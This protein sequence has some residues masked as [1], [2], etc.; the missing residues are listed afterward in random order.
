MKLIN[1][2]TIWYLGISIIVLLIGGVLIFYKL[3]SE[4]DF[5]QGKELERQLDNYARRM[6]FMENPARLK[7]DRLE[8]RELPLEAAQ[9]PFQVNDTLAWHEPLEQVERQ[10]KAGRSYLING[11]HYYMSTYN[12]MIESDDITETV[13]QTMVAIF[14]LLLIFIVVTSRLVSKKIL[15]PFHQS[16]TKINGF[17]FKE[18]APLEFE[19]SR[20]EEFE[21]LHEFLRKMS[22]RLLSD[23]KIVKE[24]SENLSHEIQTPIAI[25]S[26]KLE[27]LL[28]SPINDQQ[29]KWIAAAYQSTQKMSKTVH[30]LATLAKLENQEFEGNQRLDLSQLIHQ[31][32]AGYEE[33]IAI[34]NIRL[35]SNIAP[36]VHI[37]MHPNMAEMLVDNLLSNAIKHNQNPGYIDIVVSQNHLT[38]R[39]SG[40]QPKTDV[41][42]FLERFKKGNPSS[43]SIGL[44]L[45]IVQQICRIHGFTLD[46]QFS[47]GEHRIRIELQD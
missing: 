41:A 44:G 32:I 35:H 33:L 6:E 22:L 47:E 36:E 24:F 27:L 12:I 29:A 14:L 43:D 20:I 2:F 8:I 18:N 30:S 39:N 42:E 15:Q 13:V 37:E 1:Q 34:K 3:E 9:I 7:K 10:V 26:G 17:T 28:N 31:S 4:I 11:K 19:P 16:L 21:K 23:Y 45:S 46:Y 5:E 40:S 38:I 25:T